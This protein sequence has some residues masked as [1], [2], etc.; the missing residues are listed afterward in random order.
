MLVDTGYIF[1]EEL[2]GGKVG[3]FAFSQENVIW[4]NLKIECNGLSVFYYFGKN[5]KTTAANF[6]AFL[7]DLAMILQLLRIYDIG[8]NVGSVLI[9]I[10]TPCDDKSCHMSVFYFRAR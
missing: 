1:N 9:E 5:L 2:K 8:K 6:Q 7:N 10:E 4:N 3:F